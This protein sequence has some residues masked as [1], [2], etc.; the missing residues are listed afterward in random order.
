MSTAANPA[1]GENSLFSGVP[2]EAVDAAA[3]RMRTV[4]YPAGEVMVREG[5]L[6]DDEDRWNPFS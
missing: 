1:I 6:G 4:F 3:D 2:S 5:D